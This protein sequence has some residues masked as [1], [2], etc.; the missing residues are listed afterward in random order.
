MLPVAGETWND[1]RLYCAMINYSHVTP[2]IRH[3]SSLPSLSAPPEP[4]TLPSHISELA[5]SNWG[6]FLIN[7]VIIALTLIGNTTTLFL[8]A[9]NR[10]LQSVTNS[11]VVS[12]ACADLMMGCI[13]PLYNVLNYT[14]FYTDTDELPVSSVALQ[15]GALALSHCSNRVVVRASTSQPNPSPPHHLPLRNQTPRPAQI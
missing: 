12:L 1:P 11:F 7:N 8:I 9:R 2:S 10:K 3:A 14:T 15:L 5:V 13:Y 4:V 6:F